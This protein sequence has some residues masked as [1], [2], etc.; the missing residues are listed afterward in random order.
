MLARL[1]AAV[2]A[3]GLAAGGT[4]AAE[5]PPGRV[6]FLLLAPRGPVRVAVDV[7]VDRQPFTDSAARYRDTLLA[8]VDADGDGRVTRAEAARTPTPR[9]LGAGANA[10][11]AVEE[12]LALFDAADESGLPAEQFRA[13]VEGVM[14]PP[15]RVRQRFAGGDAADV[16]H[17]L[18]ADGDGRLTPEELR[19]DQSISHGVAG[20]YDF[21]ADGTLSAAELAPFRSATQRAERR[22]FPPSSPFR[23]LSPAAAPGLSADL[24][25]RYGTSETPPEPHL[26]LSVRLIARSFGLPRLAVVE[27]RAPERLT[28][29][30]DRRSL[31]LTVDADEAAGE[32]GLEV[33]FA[34]DRVELLGSDAISLGLLDMVRADADAND[35][36]DEMEFPAANLPGGPEFEDVDRDGDGQATRE[37]VRAY[38][39]ED[40]RLANS[41]IYLLSE[42]ARSELFG[43]LDANG[44]GR[45]TPAERVA[46][47]GAFAASGSDS[48]ALAS[49]DRDGD[50]AVVPG[51]LIGRF[52][53]HLGPGRA[54]DR[55]PSEEELETIRGREPSVPT[56]EGPEWFRRSDRNGDG[57]VTW[58][59]FVGPRDAFVRFD[60][61]GDGS[62]TPDET[63]AK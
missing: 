21:D 38:L 41:R 51:E 40:Q 4:F 47:A 14:G 37:E 8:S 18:D 59:E 63:A 3:S 46:A 23:L 24:A 20:P 19:N 48:G 1:A 28:V 34:A 58:A 7:T 25:A 54:P 50:G 49:L 6:E 5:A 42:A 30:P 10:N 39:E 13:W 17:V 56:E 12:L 60:A 44:D 55:P 31:T 9:A 32:P 29:V 57:A 26:E 2:L 15:L 35:Y 33:E 36:L 16:V 61:D 22:H 11:D 52:T 45:L 53:L 62:L 43:L 27:N